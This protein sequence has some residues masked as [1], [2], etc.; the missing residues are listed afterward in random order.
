MK[1]ESL[2]PAAQ[3]SIAAIVLLGMVG[4]SLVLAHGGFET[5]PKHGGQPVFVP[6]PLS[7][8]MAATM[9]GM[10]VLGIAAHTCCASSVRP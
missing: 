5:S 8:F 4:G 7:Y 3:L 9:Y 1:N 2:S 6:A 10:S